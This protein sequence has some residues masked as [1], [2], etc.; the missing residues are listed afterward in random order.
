MLTAL[1]HLRICQTEGILQKPSTFQIKLPIIPFFCEWQEHFFFLI[2]TLW[3]FSGCFQYFNI[4]LPFWAVWAVSADMKR[5]FQC[6]LWL[7]FATFFP[8]IIFFSSTAA[9]LPMLLSSSSADAACQHGASLPGDRSP[10]FG[11]G[12]REVTSPPSRPFL[13][14]RLGACYPASLRQLHWGLQDQ[15]PCEPSWGFRALTLLDFICEWAFDL[16][17]E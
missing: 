12:S 3:L 10:L 6:S 5:C 2:I 9:D 7:F 11:S 17:N 16:G 13:P 15:L 1:N 8:V 4:L 14:A